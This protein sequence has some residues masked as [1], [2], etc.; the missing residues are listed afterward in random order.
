[1]QPPCREGRLAQAHPNYF[2]VE[3]KAILTELT[4]WKLTEVH[5]DNAAG[6]QP[7]IPVPRCGNMMCKPL[8]LKEIG[9]ML[10]NTLG[11]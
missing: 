4:Y 1:M 11:Q 10:I 5:V 3:K 9:H 8:I 7:H 2:L 6:A